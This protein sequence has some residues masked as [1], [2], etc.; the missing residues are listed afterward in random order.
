MKGKLA[1]LCYEYSGYDETEEVSKIFFSRP[2]DWYDF[3]KVVP[4]VY[5]ELEEE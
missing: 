1:W 2:N 4:I 3:S 5:F